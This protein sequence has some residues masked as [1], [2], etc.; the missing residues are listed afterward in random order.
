[1]RYARW[2]LTALA[3]LVG[4]L[5]SVVP[6]SAQTR[7]EASGVVLYGA[8]SRVTF[9]GVAAGGG[10]VFGRWLGLE[11]ELGLATDN[12][13]ERSTA[14]QYSA[15]LNVRFLPSSSL[16]PFLAAGVAALGDTSGPYV[17][18]G[19]Y[20]WFA[21]RVALRVDARAFVP[22]NDNRPC[23]NSP[24]PPVCAEPTTTTFFRAGVTFRFGP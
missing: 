17:G 1:M 24:R 9:A 22:T 11:A 16:T 5:V 15:G 21:E 3:S 13:D 4:V 12:S 18:G 10:V 20:Y 23:L 8:D 2:G 14:A 7:G 19:I 6:A